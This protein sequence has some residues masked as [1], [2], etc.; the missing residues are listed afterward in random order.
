[1]KDFVKKNIMLLLAFL[2]PILL[3]IFVTLSAYIPSLFISTH[4]NFVY[5]ACAG[6]TDDYACGDYLQDR[7][8]VVGEKLTLVA[9][10]PYQDS[11]QDGISD[12]QENYTIRVFLHDTKKNESTELPFADAAALRLSALVTSP[13][14]ITISSSYDGGGDFF[15]INVGS[16]YG[17]YLTK[18]NSRR[19]LHLITSDNRY[20]YREQVKFLGWVLPE[21][22][23]VQYE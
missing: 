16:S 13:D 15:F 4:Y 17:H 2:L 21:A 7:Y 22:S 12:M 5:A 18:G 1:M 19:K 23:T 11:D 3:V 8:A 6:N 14:G 9:L 20:N 10:D